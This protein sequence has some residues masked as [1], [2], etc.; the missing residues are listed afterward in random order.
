MSTR[1]FDRETLLDLT[2]NLIP[3]AI[4]AFFVVVF[5][6]YSPGAFGWDSLFSTLQFSIMIT[7]FILLAVLTYYA[8]KAIAGAEKSLGMHAQTATFD[9]DAGTSLVGAEGHGD[10]E[11]ALEADAE[12]D[13]ATDSEDESS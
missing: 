9:P 12:P 5:A 8:G 13:G 4:L 1:I 10:T 6:L 7:T 3:L 11:A 2:V